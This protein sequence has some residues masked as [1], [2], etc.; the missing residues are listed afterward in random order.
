M[1][2]GF[3]KDDV[4]ILADAA[5]LLLWALLGLVA[6]LLAYI[7]I[8]GRQLHAE[9]GT[10]R[11]FWLAVTLFVLLCGA[12]TSLAGTLGPDELMVLGVLAA[13]AYIVLFVPLI[14]VGRVRLPA[15]AVLFVLWNVTVFVA[16]RFALDRFLLSAIGALVAGT[17]IVV[18]FYLTTV[19]PLISKHDNRIAYTMLFVGAIG[20]LTIL[21]LS[22]LWYF[23]D[24]VRLE[25]MAPLGIANLLQMA[26]VAISAAGIV[27]TY[28]MRSEQA[29]R[30]ANQQIY[31][32]LEL[33]SVE[34]FRFEANHPTLVAQLWHDQPPSNKAEEYILRQYI[35]QMLNLFEMA[36][37]FRERG[38]MEPEVFGSWVIWM[39]ELCECN[40]FRHFW[41]AG[42]GLPANYVKGFSETMTF[43]VDLVPKEPSEKERRKK[44][45]DQLATKLGCPEIKEWL[46]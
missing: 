20:L 16:H 25:A 30:T 38:I 18:A 33:Q 36:Y 5:I 34:L 27:F 8:F 31:Q 3:V 24:Q 12:V 42:D 32:T 44:F 40:V 7:L 2:F 9:V 13:G 29:N 4:A 26:G 14:V 35:C 46:N 41:N 22:G 39:W 37:R 28:L 43:G 23:R 1:Q 19:R 6:I 21:A 10:D 11:R 17:V 15:F 45:F